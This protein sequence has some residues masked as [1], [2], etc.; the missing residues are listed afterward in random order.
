MAW[1]M[2]GT[3]GGADRIVRSPA[4]SRAYGRNVFDWPRGM[5]RVCHSAP[6]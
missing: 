4:R 2:V 6:A 1:R 5:V 3:R